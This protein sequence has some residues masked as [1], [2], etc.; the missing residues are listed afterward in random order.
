MAVKGGI[1]FLRKRIRAIQ[2]LR[3]VTR[4]MK[5]VSSVRLRRAQPVL[6]ISSEFSKNMER[7]FKISYNGETENAEKYFSIK[8]DSSRKLYIILGSDKGLCGSFNSNISKFVQSNINIQDNSEIWVFGRRLIRILSK[9]FQIQPYEDFWRD[10]SYEKFEKVY[11]MI[12][13]RIISGELAEVYCI[14]TLFK[15]MG[16]QVPYIERVFPVSVSLVWEPKRIFEPSFEEFARFF[17]M[18]YVRSKLFFCFQSSI[19]SEHAARM[20]AM[21]MAT[22]NSERVQRQLILQMNKARQEAITKELIDIVSGKNAL[23]AQQV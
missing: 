1:K 20:R 21:D 16:T 13:Q 5:S 3:K 22:Q 2:N 11:N 6:Q 15:S 8:T 17:I 10:F 4:A 7:I 9:K 12:E 19:T 18:S 14:Y 23:E